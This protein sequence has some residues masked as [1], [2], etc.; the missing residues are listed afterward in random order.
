M[1]NFKRNLIKLFDKHTDTDVVDGLDW[2]KKARVFCYRVAQKNFVPYIK[3]CGIMAALSPR[4]KW[5]RNKID[6][7]NLIKYMQDFD[8]KRPLFGTYDKMV[9]KAELIFRC[10]GRPETIKRILNGPKIVS[11]FDNIYD[12]E[13]SVVTVDTWMLLAASG[14]YMSVDTRPAL[15]KKQY[16]EIESAIK[17]LSLRVQLRPYELQAILWTTMKRL[18][19]P[20]V[21]DQK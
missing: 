17:E 15:T 10:D 2:Y 19:G 21:K 11:F 13:S 12:T 9:E 6:V 8:S 14:K 1:I 5:E 3:V 16:T 20:A 4:N 18:N 7:E